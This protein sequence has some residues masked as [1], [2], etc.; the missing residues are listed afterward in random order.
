MPSEAVRAEQAG[1]V[2]AWA[3]QG[4]NGTVSP[5]GLELQFLETP[6]RDIPTKGVTP[7]II[8]TH[9]HTME[10]SDDSHLPLERAVARAK[11]LGMDGLCITDHDTLKLAP[12]AQELT[13]R[14]GFL[15]LVGV[16]ILTYQGDLLVYGVDSIPTQK[17]HAPELSRLVREM[18]GAS[19][20]AHPFRDNGRGMGDVMRLCSFMDGAEIF[21]GSTKPHHNR[22]A[23]DM[24][25]ELSL[26][27]LGGS[28]SHW[29]DRLG[30]F[31]TRFDGPIRSMGDLVQAIK[32]RATSPVTYDLRSGLWVSPE[33]PSREIPMREAIA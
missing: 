21:N 22:Q 14:Y 3:R 33:L 19:A 15:I 12:M 31:A 26:A 28:D 4:S 13:D 24:A 23:V 1:R 10:G 32:D 30:L 27:T 17:M 25:Q 20:A 7:L 29:E 6:Y 11:E 8:D 18:G 9:L 2:Y 5:R 16:E